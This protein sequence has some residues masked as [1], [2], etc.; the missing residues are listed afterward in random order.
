MNEKALSSLIL[1]T[2]AE[3][4]Q[5][6]DQCISDM[7]RLRELMDRDQEDIERLKAGTRAKL[8]KLRAE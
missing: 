3:Y 2:D 6:I 1:R 5:A 4:Q 7:Q 8:A